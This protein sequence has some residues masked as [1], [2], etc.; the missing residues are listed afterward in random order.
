MLGVT[1]KN[2]A[3]NQFFT[4]EIDS[5]K[6]QFVYQKIIIDEHRNVTFIMLAKN[7]RR[8]LLFT[9]DKP[10]LNDITR[11]KFHTKQKTDGC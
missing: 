1:D 5:E 4:I 8:Y 11:L 6:F 10:K 7:S 2:P 3:A 9:A